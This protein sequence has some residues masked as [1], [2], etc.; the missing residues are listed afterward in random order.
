MNRSI[1]TKKPHYFRN[2]L[3]VLFIAVVIAGF[4][5]IQTGQEVEEPSVPI[6]Y[7]EI[8]E[9]IKELELVDNFNLS[10]P[11][12]YL[13]KDFKILG[14]LTISGSTYKLWSSYFESYLPL[15]GQIQSSDNEKLIIANGMMVELPQAEY[16]E[17]YKSPTIAL[18]VSSY[19]ELGNVK[20]HKYLIDKST[21]YTT[22]KFGCKPSQD[23]Y[24]G[25]IIK[26]N[27]LYFKVRWV[28]TD[29]NKSEDK[30]YELWI[31]P[32]SGQVINEIDETKGFHVC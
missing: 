12:V 6:D 16:N 29:M 28:F 20:Y 15:L 24:I 23:R 21:D 9:Q 18:Q 11:D 7:I 22:N 4:W 3:I 17:N 31:D 1:F 14:I 32:G 27:K 26:D 13:G 2:L 19:E 5:Y 30:Y 25:F 8:G 10:N